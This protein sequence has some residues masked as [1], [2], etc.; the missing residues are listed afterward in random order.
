MIAPQIFRPSIGSAFVSVEWVFSHLLVTNMAENRLL[1]LRTC[2]FIGM[3]LCFSL[4]SYRSFK[5]FLDGKSSLSESDI[6][7]KYE[8]LPT[9]TICSEPPFDGDYMKSDLKISPNFFLFT[10]YMNTKDNGFEFPPNLSERSS[11]RHV[12][13]NTNLRIF[14]TFFFIFSSTQNWGNAF[15]DQYGICFLFHLRNS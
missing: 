11:L 4:Q 8:P 14:L 1:L 13:S 3:L 7:K 10:S 6:S 15:F 2:F 5:K 12:F 9:F